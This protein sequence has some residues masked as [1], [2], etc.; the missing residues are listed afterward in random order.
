MNEHENDVLGSNR[1][2]FLKGGSVA[3][4]MTLA[5]QAARFD[6]NVPRGDWLPSQ[7]ESVRALHSLEQMD[8]V[9]MA[10]CLAISARLNLLINSS[11]LPLNIHPAI[12]S[13]H[14]VFLGKE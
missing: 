12:T 7:A 1:R 5:S 10:F 9:G 3:A 4:L 14:P 13:I 8:R 6:T 2:D 11:V